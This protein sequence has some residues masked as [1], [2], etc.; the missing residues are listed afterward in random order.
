[1]TWKDVKLAALHKLFAV[2]GDEPVHNDNTGQYMAAMPAAAN[3]GLQL[4]ACAGYGPVGRIAIEHPAGTGQGMTLYDL[5]EY[6]EDFWRLKEDSVRRRRGG[7]VQHN[8]P[9]GWEGQ[10]GF[11]VFGG[12]ACVYEME[13]YKAP[14]LLG[15]G[16]PDDFV[17]P[18]KDAAAVLLPLYIAAQLYKEDD[19]QQAA[20]YRNEFEAG[21]ERLRPGTRANECFCSERGWI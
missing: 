19:L 13:Y 4:L 6:A 17:M 15:A 21:L 7:R 8:P 2:E 5:G 16:T 9:Y 11:L 1:M 18:L 14:P 12:Q 20:V 3:E 10:R